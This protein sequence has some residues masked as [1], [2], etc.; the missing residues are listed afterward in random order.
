MRYASSV[1]CARVDIAPRLANLGLFGNQAV[2]LDCRER[3]AR[4]HAVGR[5]FAGQWIVAVWTL[6]CDG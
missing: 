2:L 6:V 1:T 5:V 4:A 3:S